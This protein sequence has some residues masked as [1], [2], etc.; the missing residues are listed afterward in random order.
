[1]IILYKSY[2]AGDFTLMDESYTSEQ[3]RRIKHNV[4]RLLKHRGYH[5]SKKY[6]ETIPFTI[7]DAYNNFG[8]EFFILYAVLPITIY[9]HL[10]IQKG[11][12][13]N[14]DAFAKLRN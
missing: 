11:S 6:F 10:R 3:F 7:H 13:N 4:N 5:Q 9:E 8:D 12:P 2:G 1:M 14:K